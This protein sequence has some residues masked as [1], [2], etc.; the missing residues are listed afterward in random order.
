MGGLGGWFWT[1]NKFVYHFI[2]REKGLGRENGRLVIY[3]NLLITFGIKIQSFFAQIYGNKIYLTDW[4]S[5]LK[6]FKFN[7]YSE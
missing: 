1:R 7:F 4:Y 3:Y 5:F 2:Q 6:N